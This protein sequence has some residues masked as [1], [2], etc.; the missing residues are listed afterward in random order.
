MDNRVGG[1]NRGELA[2]CYG[3]LYSDGVEH[4]FVRDRAGN[5]TTF[6]VPGA[7][8]TQ[9]VGMNEAGIIVGTFSD[10]AG[11]RGFVREVSGRIRVV[12]YPGADA[13]SPFGLNNR[14]KFIGFS[15]TA[16]V[17]MAICGMAPTSSHR[18]MFP[19]CHLRC[20]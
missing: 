17:F 13:S 16:Q 8:I 1:T 4:E 7:L 5:I 19:A 12:D 10:G 11:E 15:K 3:D 20:R 2:G 9:P 6:D 14:G 18:S